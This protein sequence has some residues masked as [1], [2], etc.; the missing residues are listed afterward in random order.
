MSGLRIR[1]LPFIP[2][3]LS[4]QGSL[5]YEEEGEKRVAWLTFAPVV[6]DEA[7]EEVKVNEISLTSGT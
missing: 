1:L 7:Q 2:R 4:T 5:V 6:N 3:S